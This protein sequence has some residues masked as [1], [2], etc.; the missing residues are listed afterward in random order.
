MF[1]VPPSV[2]DESRGSILIQL[3]TEEEVL[4]D[5]PKKAHCNRLVRNR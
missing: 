2:S 3:E 4:A 1:L 5:T